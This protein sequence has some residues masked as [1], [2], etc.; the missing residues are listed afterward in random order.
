MK[1]APAMKPLIICCLVTLAYS[2]EEEECVRRQPYG[3]LPCYALERCRPSFLI[4]GVGKCG[5]SSLY[6]Y[7]TAHPSVVGAIQKQIQWFDHQYKAN[8]FE[9]MYLGRSFPKRLEAGQMTGEASPGYVQYSQVPARV[10]RHLPDTRILIIVRDPAERA[11]SSYYYNYLNAA[12]DPLSFE[13]L[14]SKEIELLKT[15]LKATGKER[16]IDL[17]ADCYGKTS[18]RLTYG[19]LGPGKLPGRQ[20]LWRQLVGRSLYSV[21]LDWWPD[22]FFV[23]CSELLGD[24]RSAVDEMNRVTEFL[25]LP[26]YDFAPVVALGKY[27]AGSKHEGYS[28]L[29]TWAEAAELKRPDMPLTARQLVD[30]FAHPFSLRLFERAQRQCPHWSRSM[31]TASPASTLAPYLRSFL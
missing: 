21:Y 2:L 3:G 23:V 25:D 14:V 28:H 13:F 1:A 17:N 30:H 31:E 4:I 22:G 16:K 8:S 18:A 6:Y 15:C 24:P 11:Y 29:T 12:R 19:N 7:L 26:R 9:E 10:F 27:N 5:T 20:H